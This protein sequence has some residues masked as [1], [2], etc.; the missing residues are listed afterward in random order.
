MSG[1][2]GR[3]ITSGNFRLT[4]SLF[5]LPF[6]IGTIVLVS[7]C[8]MTVAGETTVTRQ[9]DRLSIFTGIGGLGWRRNYLW[10]D[11]RVVREDSSG[12][13]YGWNRQGQVVALEGKRRATFGGMWTQER[14]YF[15]LNALRA[16]LKDSNG[17]PA[18]ISPPRFR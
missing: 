7:L 16:M 17:S 4:E 6:L 8:A 14:R 2:Y 3:Q 5:G 9:S 11:F 12:N 10:S 13:R 18:S 1:I 15:V